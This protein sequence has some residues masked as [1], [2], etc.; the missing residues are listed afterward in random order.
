APLRPAQR[1]ASARAALRLRSRAVRGLLGPSGRQGD[2]LVRDAGGRRFRQGDHDA[3]G[4]AG[5]LGEGARHGGCRPCSASA[6]PGV[7]R[8]SGAAL[9]LLPERDDDPGR[10]SAL[11]HEEPDRGPDPHR[12]ERASLPLWHLSADP[13]CDQA[14][15]R[16]DGE[17]GQVIM[18][19][20]M[21]EKEFSRK[22]F[23]KGGGVLLVSYGALAGAANAAT[24]NTPFNKRGPGDYL[25]DLNTID[26]WLA[27]TPDN[28]VIISHGEPEFAGTPTGI[29]MLAAEELN[30]TDMGMMEYAHPESWLNAT[31]G[32][33]GSGGISS[34]STQLRAAAAYAHQQ[35]LNMAS[36]QLGVPVSGLSSSNGVI[37]GGGKSVKFSDLMGGKNFN[38]NVPIPT[39]ATNSGLIPQQGITKQVKD[40]KLV[41][42]LVHRIDIPAK[43]MGTYTYIHN[44]RV[45]GMVHARRV[46]P[47]GAGAN[48]SQNHYPLSVDPKSIA[49]IPGAQVVQINN[50][51]AVV[52]PRE[53][54]AIQAA[55]QLKVVWKDDPKFGSG[56]TG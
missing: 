39:G 42:K 1:A 38:F 3:R 32:G 31:G 28:K 54:D 9:R 14:G 51:L 30:V 16:G 24:G 11:D 15:R 52:A 41:G 55:A 20:F 35:L 17:G 4:P 56:S 34:R 2:S 6:A 26:A 19:G 50:F 13:D 33:G 43:V 22:T 12:H 21:H 40:Y 36:T 53:Y 47:R 27:I 18:T 37:T 23:L 5:S 29:L 45:P 25:P 44:V 48:S 10:G 8:R 7:D 49:H 46:R